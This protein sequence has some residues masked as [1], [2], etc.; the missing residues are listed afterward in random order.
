MKLTMLTGLTLALLMG[1]P[2]AQASM[3]AEMVDN[4]CHD[5]EYYDDA[6]Y[7]DVHEN[8]DAKYLGDRVPVET[9]NL[10][11]EYPESVYQL[12]NG[13]IVIVQYNPH[14]ECYRARFHTDGRLKVQPVG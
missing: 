11:N 10:G 2:M 6:S 1:T 3:L 5:P 4:E 12:Q 13:K 14:E 8:G 7:Y 9:D